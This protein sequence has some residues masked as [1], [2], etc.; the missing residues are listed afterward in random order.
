MAIMK[1]G[2][3]QEVDIRKLCNKMGFQ[4]NKEILRCQRSLMNRGRVAYMNN[5]FWNTLDTITQNSEQI[6]IKYSG[7]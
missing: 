6:R 3:L 5:L 7:I 2:K 4:L 1:L